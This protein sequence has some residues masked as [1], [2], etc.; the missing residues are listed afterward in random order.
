[1]ELVLDQMERD[2]SLSAI[3][4]QRVG[5]HHIHPARVKMHS[6][7]SVFQSLGR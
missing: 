1:M 3:S 5:T 2:T 7:Y 6:Y 4:A